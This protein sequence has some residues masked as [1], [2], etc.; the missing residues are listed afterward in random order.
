M[1]GIESFWWIKITDV[2]NS[3]ILLATIAAIIFGPIKA[4]AI[5]RK[6]DELRDAYRRKRDIFAAL[7]RTRNAGLTPDHVWALNLIQVEFAECES[8]VRA[9]RDYIANLSEFLPDPGPAFDT[10][11]RKRRDLFFDLLHE[12]AKVVGFNL[13]KRDLERAAYYPVGWEND[14][15]ELR[16]FRRAMLEL[17]HGKRPLPVAPFEAQ[18]ATDLFPPSPG[19]VVES[20]NHQK[21]KAA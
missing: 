3:A 6:N 20:P 14:E 17:L 8:V 9:Y 2:I 18:V 15:A 13:D 12:I 5:G 7:M 21:P 16:Q 19:P 11:T 1:N 10:F 4:V